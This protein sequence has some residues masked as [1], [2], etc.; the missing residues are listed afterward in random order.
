[1][2]GDRSKL[3]ELEYA[4]NGRIGT[5]DLDVYAQKNLDILK[6]KTGLT[7][8]KLRGVDWFLTFNEW[9]NSAVASL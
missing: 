8:D 2:Y 9:T 3:N 7:L 1:M 4:I 6:D 5:D